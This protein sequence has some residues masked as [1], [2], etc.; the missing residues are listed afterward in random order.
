M[1]YLIHLF[2]LCLQMLIDSKDKKA[3]KIRN[4]RKKG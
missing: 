1:Q 4:Y 2:F 3:T